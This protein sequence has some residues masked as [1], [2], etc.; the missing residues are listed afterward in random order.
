MGA[1]RRGTPHG[2]RPRTS[3]SIR[4]ERFARGNRQGR[5]ICVDLAAAALRTDKGDRCRGQGSPN[6]SSTPPGRDRPPSAG[7][8][9][10]ATGRLAAPLDDPCAGRSGRGARREPW[11]E[12][13]RV[14]GSAS[15]FSDAPAA[16]PPCEAC[17]VAGQRRARHNDEPIAADVDDRPVSG[18]GAR[19]F[20]QARHQPSRSAVEQSRHRLLGYVWALGGAHRWVLS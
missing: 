12:A 16:Q 1:V 20:Q 14:I 17:E 15:G 6:L 2:N 10:R 19:A 3:C 11:E 4:F 7:E 9:D 18:P 8:A 13:A 5:R